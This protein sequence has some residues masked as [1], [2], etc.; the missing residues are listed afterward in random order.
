MTH[1]LSPD[2][3]DTKVGE[4]V[5]TEATPSM[6]PKIEYVSLEVKKHRDGMDRAGIAFELTLPMKLMC[7]DRRSAWQIVDDMMELLGERTPADIEEAQRFKKPLEA[8]EYA[9][10]LSPQEK[11]AAKS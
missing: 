4:F 6:G 5:A 7:F 8:G 10:P 3:G 9:L 1:E 11:L 2:V